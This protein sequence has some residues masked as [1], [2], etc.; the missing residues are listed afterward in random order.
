MNRGKYSGQT[1]FCGRRNRKLKRYRDPK[2]CGLGHMQWQ[3]PSPPSPT[4]SVATCFFGGWKHSE[5]YDGLL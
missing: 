3:L 4:D 2:S 1:G 5:P